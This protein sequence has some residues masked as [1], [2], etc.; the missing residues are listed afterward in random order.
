MQVAPTRVALQLRHKRPHVPPHL[1]A[2]HHGRGGAHLQ[3]VGLVPPE[4]AREARRQRRSRRKRQRVCARREALPTAH[5]LHSAQ[6]RV[7]GAAGAT[8]GGHAAFH[9]P[10][11]S[12]DHAQAGGRLLRHPRLVPHLQAL[13]FDR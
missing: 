13:V 8:L 7:H 5:A 6:L 10:L 4:A 3:R 12:H 1:R 2:A 11:L 9:V